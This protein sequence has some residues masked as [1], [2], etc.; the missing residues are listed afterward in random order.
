MSQRGRATAKKTESWPDR[1]MQR[2]ENSKAMDIILSG[3]DSVFAPGTSAP[4]V[5]SIKEEVYILRP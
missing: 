4:R 3:H 2:E 5:L 1:I